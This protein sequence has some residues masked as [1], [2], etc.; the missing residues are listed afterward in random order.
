MN[1]LRF[2][3]NLIVHVTKLI[4]YIIQLGD[5]IFMSPSIIIF[6]SDIINKG[7]DHLCSKFMLFFLFIALLLHFIPSFKFIY[8]SLVLWVQYPENLE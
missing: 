7:G 2:S 8:R 6:W 4:V 1:G 5:N 3:D